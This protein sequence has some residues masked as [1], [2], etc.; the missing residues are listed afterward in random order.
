ISKERWQEAKQRTLET[1]ASSTCLNVMKHFFAD[2][3]ATRQVY[4]RSD[5]REFIFE[6]NIED[7]IAADD[8]SVFVST[9]HKAKGRE[10]DTVY[11]LSPIPDGRDI[12]DMRAYYVGLTR[13]KQNLF[14]V[15]NPPVEYSSISIALNMHD[16][17][18]NFFKGRKDI[19]LRLRSGDRLQYQDGYL[20]NDQGINIIALSASGK[21]KL[22]V[23]ADKGYEVTNAKVSYTLAWKPQNSETEYAVCLANVVLSK[24]ENKK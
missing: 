16:V 4:Y 20:L 3:E 9:I 6:S 2:F 5:L 7:F 21:E 13:A 14:L 19:V 23:W 18:L 12:N 24:A 15:T 22:K 17:I 1:Y 11:L 8:Q 10:F